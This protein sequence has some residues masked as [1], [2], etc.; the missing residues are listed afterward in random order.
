MKITD[1]RALPNG[2]LQLPAFGLGG[3]ALGG[4]FAPVGGDDASATLATAWAAGVRYFDTAPYYG[5]TRSERRL[6]VFLSEQARESFVL[7]TKIGRLMVPDASASL[8]TEGWSGPLPF[9]PHFDY[10]HDAVMRSFEDSLQR[11]GVAHVDILLVHDIG[12]MTHGDT[13]SGH[14]RQLTE[15]GGFRAL[16]ELRRDGRVSAIGL[17]VNETTVLRAAMQE[18]QLDCTLLAGRYTLLEQAGL[19]PLLHECL[20]HGN[21]L[22]VG[23]PFNSGVLAGEAH[24]NYAEA[25]AAVLERVRA[26]EAACREHQVPLPA[27][28][29]QFPLAHPAVLSVVAGVRHPGQLQQNIAWFEQPIP[30]E[31][32][33]TLR[34]RGLLDEDAPCPGQRA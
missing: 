31:L 29:L 22:V 20:R 12:R 7:S 1:T 8:S 11:L 3:A 32:W 4:L 26:L 28:A 18:C 17:G 27:A 23:G 9:R 6:G 24:Y 14:W 10:S 30:P 21:A 34:E 5:H 2:R 16:G 13:H 33:V 15:G 25:P 19:Q